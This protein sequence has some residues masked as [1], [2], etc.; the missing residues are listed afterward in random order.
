MDLELDGKTALITGASKG[1]GLGVAQVLAS[2]GVDVILAARTASR[3]E[4]AAEQIRAQH[5][6]EVTTV[7][8][9]LSLPAD[10]ARLAEI[11]TAGPLDIIVNNAGAIPGGSLS[12]IDEETWRH[13]WDLKVFGYINLTRMLLPHLEAAGSGV[14]LNVIGA[15]AVRPSPGYIAG[16]AGNSALVGFTKA[17]GSRSLRDGVRVLAVNPGLIITDRMT[18]LLR[19]RAETELGDGDRWEELLTTDPAPG[20]V[21]QVADVVAFLVSIRAG[22]ISGTAITIDGGATAR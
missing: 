6:V 4:P 1:I 20:T 18:D 5:G 15:A 22:H 13:A 14:I 16:A 3:L 21:A 17:L 9:D 10:Q 2:E 19:Q 8:V 11:A 7:A 12:E